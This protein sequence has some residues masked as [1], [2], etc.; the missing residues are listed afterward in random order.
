MA[1]KDDEIKLYT[2]TDKELRVFVDTEVKSMVGWRLVEFPD[3]FITG[4][5]LVGIVHP[6]TSSGG[7]DYHLHP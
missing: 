3:P 1:K 6:H 4:G 5:V 2:L 7:L